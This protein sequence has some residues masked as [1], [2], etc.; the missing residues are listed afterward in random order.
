MTTPRTRCDCG[1]PLRTHHDDLFGSGH[2][3]CGS[4]T[5]DDLVMCGCK[6]PTA[7]GDRISW[8]GYTDVELHAAFDLVKPKNWKMPIHAFVNKD[9]DLDLIL[10]AV[11]YFTGSMVEV[12]ED[13]RHPG[14]I[15]VEAAGLS[16]V[17]IAPHR[18][19]RVM[20]T[21]GEGEPM[22]VLYE[23]DAGPGA[24]KI[25]DEEWDGAFASLSLEDIGMIGFNPTLQLD[26]LTHAHSDDG[27]AST[28]IELNVAE[29]QA[30]A[31]VLTT[32]AER[33]AEERS[34][35]Q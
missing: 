2:G 18:F 17:P 27:V 31:A 34:D 4:G 32:W 11:L 29:A 35:D 25:G 24:V 10:E 14:K 1:H 5:P 7:K 30:L 8:G 6:F 15:L 19:L 20:R 33:A 9:A 23:I 3:P 22:T 26:I 12:Y 21:P 13:P 28:S 16:R